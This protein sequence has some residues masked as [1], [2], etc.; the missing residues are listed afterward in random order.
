[1]SAAQA[2]QQNRGSERILIDAFFPVQSLF[3]HG[4]IVA[5]RDHD[6]GPDPVT[7]RRTQMTVSQVTSS[8][9]EVQTLA[10]GAGMLRWTRRS[11]GL[12]CSI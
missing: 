8:E 7:A 1:M 4:A 2:D 3:V 12:R 6:G 10:A 5:V 11:L 9:P